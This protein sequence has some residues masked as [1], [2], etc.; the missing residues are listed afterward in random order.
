VSIRGKM[1]G[2]AGRRP[3]RYLL[4]L[5]GLLVA[6]LLVAC[7]APGSAEVS[8]PA[9]GSSPVATAQLTVFAAASLTD[10]FNDLG[11]SFATT[12]AG[13]RVRFSYAGSPTLR[14][15]LAQGARAD[16][17]ASADEP[18]MQGAQQDG[19]IA[20]TPKIFVSNR[21][22]VIVPRRNPAGI[23][24]LPDLGRSGVKLVLAAANVP[25]GNYARQSLTKM[26]GDPSFGAGFTQQ[27]L[28]NVV[29]DE[30]DVKQVV[31]KVQ[32]GEADAGI[33]Y[34][35]D[36]TAAVRPQV[37]V[38]AIPD[39]YNV[40]ARYPIAVV[41]GSANPTA[42]QAFIDYVLSPTGQATLEHYGFIPVAPTGAPRG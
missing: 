6:A 11:Q 5:P 10:A 41:E 1:V 42:A 16:L 23:T 29:S 28:A 27:A 14:T 18:N 17:F 24:T 30:T 22:V 32:L 21:L 4:G 34:S 39:P 40:V 25:V 33:V 20:S 7:G 35:S 38:I 37:T 13:A 19:T 36:V 12:P 8:T 2:F 26:G 31:A 3:L 9:A 15:Q